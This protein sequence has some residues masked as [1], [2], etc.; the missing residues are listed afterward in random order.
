MDIKP[1]RLFRLRTDIPHDERVA[2]ICAGIQDDQLYW[3]V[4]S[5]PSSLGGYI[6]WFATTYRHAMGISPQHTVCKNLPMRYMQAVEYH[7]TDLLTT[8][9]K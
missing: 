7:Q 1:T 6:G 8:E 9:V 2:A 5:R 3:L 4:S